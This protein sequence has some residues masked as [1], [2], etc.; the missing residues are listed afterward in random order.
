MLEDDDLYGVLLS[1]FFLAEGMDDAYLSALL[2]G[3]PGLYERAPIKA[4]MA[5]I[6]IVNT[7]GEG[8]EDC[9]VTFMEM[10]QNG[11]EETRATLLEVAKVIGEDLEELLPMQRQS[12]AIL[13]RSIGG[14]A[15]VFEA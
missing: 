12:M 6:R 15:S 4:E 14:D 1:V 10:A 5:V 8:D 7:F 13:V 3:L 11:S 2:Q 9:T